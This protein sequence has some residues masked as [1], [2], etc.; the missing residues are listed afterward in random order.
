VFASRLHWRLLVGTILVLMAAAWLAPRWVRPPDIQE[1]RVLAPKPAWPHGLADLKLFRKAADAYVADHFP[2]RPHLIGALNRIRMLAGVSGSPKVIVGREGWLFFDDDSHL[3]P[4]RGDPPMPP[5]EI[6]EWL[7]ALAGRREYV[8][9]HG[10]R[11]LVLTPPAKEAVYPQHGPWWFGGPNPNRPT[12]LLPKLAQASGAGEVVYLYPAVAAATKAG[13]KT[14]SR[15]DTHWT[16]YGAYAGYVGLM[17]RLHALGLTAEGPKRLADFDKVPALGA[18]LPRDLALMLGVASFVDLDYP[19]FENLRGQA[20][21]RTTYLS[22]KQDWTGPQVID[23]GQAGKPVLLMTRD[24]F[25]NE[26]LPFLLPHFSRIVLA[27]NQDGVWRP[28]LIARFKPDIVI[29]EV[30][31]AGLRVSL[32]EGPPP[33]AEAAARIDRLLRAARPKAPPTPRAPPP[34]PPPPPPTLAP[35]DAKSLAVIAAAR[36]T[37]NC[38]LEAA[39]LGVAP[40]GTPTLNV[41]GWISELGRGVTSPRGFV[42]LSGPSGTLVAALRVDSPRPDVAAFFKNPNGEKSGFSASLRAGKLAPGA[43][44]PTVYRRAGDGWIACAGKAPLAAR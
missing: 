19:H 12:V 22:P 13:Q 2:I 40:D 5:Q 34:P 37:D 27:H 8:R 20:R 23:T 11:Y 26:L 3:G 21:A 41:A 17:T 32:G 39:S 44:A 7:T 42:A 24:S 16:G 25:S 43:Y 4:V 28:D 38:N 29:L 15:H 9:A 14:F 30:I 31:E 35:A 18:K 6:R 10:A 33:S 1:N 36:R